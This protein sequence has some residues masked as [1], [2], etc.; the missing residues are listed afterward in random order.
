M[1][2]Y[3][4][5]PSIRL[6]V[7]RKPL[8]ID[9]RV[10]AAAKHAQLPLEWDEEGRINF[11]NFDDG[12]RL[13]N[14]LGSR[15]L[16]PTEFWSVFKDTDADLRSELT[17]DRYTEWLDRVYLSDKMFIE[18]PSVL[19][20]F[21]Y[22]GERQQATYLDG[23]PGWFN[24]EENINGNGEP[25]TLRLAREKYSSN[26]K[27]WSPDYDVTK[28]KA[29][30]PIRGYVTSVGKPSLDLGIPP[31]SRQP[32][33][34][35]RECRESPLN[36]VID[37]CILDEAIRLS[38]APST[39]LTDFLHR[40]AP[41]FRGSSDSQI[42]KLREVF[43]DHLGKLA[44]QGVR[45]SD[46]ANLG[47][48]SRALFE[49]YLSGSQRRLER[50]I[51]S[52]QDIVF[53]MGHKNPDTDTVVSSLFEGLRNHLM[54]PRT[55]YI[56]VVQAE[57]MPD[58]VQELLG[59][60]AKSIVL[61]NDPLYADARKSGLARWISVD[62]NREPEVQR[63]FVSI[64]DHHV[65]SA[66]AKQRDLP[67]TLE[68]VGST[69]GLVTRK[70][71]GMNGSLDTELARIMYGATLMDTEN[72]SPYKM[73]AHDEEVMGYLRRTSGVRSDDTFYAQLM[74]RLLSTDDAQHLFRRDYKEDWGFGF[75]VAKIRGGFDA[76]GAVQ[77]PGLIAR[78]IELGYQNTREKNLP[79][80]LVK[81][82]DYREDN[83]TVNRERVHLAFNANASERFRTTTTRL[84]ESII[85]F[86]FPDHQVARS[87]SAIE[88]WGNG[89]Q[90][91]RK[92]TAPVL[93][94]VVAAFNQY[95]YSPSIDKWV[96]RD[97]LKA[98]TRVRA[99]MP[100]I[101]HDK[102]GRVNHLTFLDA[103]ALATQLDMSL[104]SL[105]E[106]WNVF[107]D[108]RRS[109]DTQMLTSLQGSNFVE[110][111]DSAIENKDSLIDHPRFEGDKTIGVRRRVMIPR[112][113]PGLIHPDDIDRATGIPRIVRPPNEYGN[114]ALWR[115]WEPDAALVVPCRSYIFLLAQPCWD[116]KFHLGESFENLGMRPVLGHNSEPEVS[117]QWNEDE[118]VTVIK[119]EGE[120]HEHRWP[121][122]IAE[123][124]IE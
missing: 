118:L 45:S 83:K 116:G 86:E 94:P 120:R 53:V 98:I 103:K 70:I 35:L 68:M 29:C 75:A 50:A 74:G 52:S 33:L 87:D 16:S 1:S 82:T 90:L 32:V 114:P 64:I 97:Y 28:L 88:F 66:S 8:T 15:M 117:V 84:L 123:L 17:S 18:H 48:L 109:N 34:M 99:A 113:S 56:P 67:K 121:R 91:S 96:K 3:Y 102:E 65:V 79:L 49:D 73:T 13:L 51:S 42:H 31:D 85:R 108:A 6:Y 100:G 112:G 80:T 37:T 44:L 107:D 12:R 72:R 43:F 110:F 62:Q 81:I 124:D 101:S 22:D 2:D 40:Y 36:P 93:E 58:E 14:A 54:D 11:V 5:S 61:T 60:L 9:A 20:G 19:G 21:R 25:A 78:L 111:L 59:P 119:M 105:G 57:R 55:T 38:R 92:K 41:L 115:Y 95:F 122:R 63:Y 47:E 77:K 76:H 23:R 30:V 24:P 39:E 71:L 69:A 26:W 4:Y 46:L 10:A 104:L 106:Y 27:Y 7:A 89:M